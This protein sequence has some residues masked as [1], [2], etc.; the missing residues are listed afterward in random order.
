MKAEIVFEK[1][2][3][4]DL[5]MDAPLKSLAFINREKEEDELDPFLAS[6]KGTNKFDNAKLAEEEAA[7]PKEAGA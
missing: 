7:E 4:I 1:T 6:L 3:E 2:E 5:D